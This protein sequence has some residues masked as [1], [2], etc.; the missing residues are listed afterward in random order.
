M[1]FPR[2]SGGRLPTTSRADGSCVARGLAN[3]FL[4]ILGLTSRAPPRAV[5]VSGERGSGGAAEWAPPLQ[6]SKSDRGVCDGG[7]RMLRSS[8]SVFL[9]FPT[10]TVWGGGGFP[11]LLCGTGVES[12]AERGLRAAACPDKMAQPPPSTLAIFPTTA[13]CLL[14][15]F[16]T[17]QPQRRAYIG[18]CVRANLR[19]ETSTER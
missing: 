7:G 15:S 1:V 6:C 18:K 4:S 5:A 10:V 14:G 8:S 16:D 12:W 9:L 2:R 3:A 13:R 17:H 19:A 11:W